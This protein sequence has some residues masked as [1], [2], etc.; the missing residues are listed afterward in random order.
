MIYERL[1]EIVEFGVAEDHLPRWLRDDLTKWHRD[2][3][4]VG[5]TASRRG[6][7]RAAMLA[8]A[9]DREQLERYRDRLSQKS[10]EY[11]DKPL[12]EAQQSCA[13]WRDD[14]SRGRTRTR[15]RTGG[16]A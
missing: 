7:S 13:T 16:R 5:Q 10:P 2:L 15:R 14:S 11:H 4:D 3:A 8:A 9:D 6:E 12:D 1:P